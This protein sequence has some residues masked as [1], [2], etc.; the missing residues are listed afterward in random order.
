MSIEDKLREI[1]GAKFS[2][3]SYV[4][5]DWNG[6]D[7]VLNKVALPAI[8]CILPTGGYMDVGATGIKDSEDLL[9]AFVDKV[10]RDADGDDNEKVYTRMKG[11]AR[12]F[13]VAMNESYYF[14]PIGG[15]VRYTTIL[16][17]GATNIT[18]V[19]V[20]LSVKERQGGCV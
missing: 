17:S 12:S 5:E 14:A 8:I 13:I 1:V 20:E 6:A 11:V 7:R 18:G 9:L 16:E 19:L 4:F 10:A 2:G 3:Y 15:Q